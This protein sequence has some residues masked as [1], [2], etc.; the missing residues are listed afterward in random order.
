MKIH[1][2]IAERHNDIADIGGDLLGDGAGR[3]ARKGPIEVEPVDG[4]GPAPGQNCGQIDR[5]QEDDAAADHA[6]IEIA[7]QL[8]KRDRPL[9]FVAMVA[10]LQDDCRPGAIADHGERNTGRAPRILVGRMRDVD[11]AYLLAGAVEVDGGAGCRHAGMFS[12]KLSGDRSGGS[13]PVPPPPKGQIGGR[14]AGSGVPIHFSERAE[15]EPSSRPR[16]M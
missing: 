4:G 5:R 9:I 3:I 1:I 6:R 16:W 12:L 13:D 8:A 11:E 2:G 10:R 14:F 15:S 7:D